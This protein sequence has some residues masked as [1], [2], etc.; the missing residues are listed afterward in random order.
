MGVEERSYL[1]A[2]TNKHCLKLLVLIKL[3]PHPDT[4]SRAYYLVG[5]ENPCSICSHL[6]L[7][8]CFGGGEVPVDF[9][10]G[11]AS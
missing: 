10:D 1:C 11:G 8:N 2:H 3:K 4:W 9:K 7:E 6:L 5:L